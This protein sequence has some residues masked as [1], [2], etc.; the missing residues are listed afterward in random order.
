MTP[1]EILA[2]VIADAMR[3]YLVSA[4]PAVPTETALRLA[5][6]DAVRALDELADRELP[7]HRAPEIVAPEF[8]LDAARARC[9][10]C[11]RSSWA[12][13][14]VGTIDRMTQPD[15]RPCGGTFRAS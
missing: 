10:R 9:D 13:D 7:R 1:D 8:V 15:G 6:T 4:T 12:P 14:N 2:A 5:A 11:G 3:P